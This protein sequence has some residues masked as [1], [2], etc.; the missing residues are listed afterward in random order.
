MG[1]K[2]LLEASIKFM[3]SYMTT[4]ERQC[5]IAIID[6]SIAFWNDVCMDTKDYDGKLLILDM[7]NKLCDEREAI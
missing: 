5:L 1:Y 6:K 7:I 3:E 4:R 2:R